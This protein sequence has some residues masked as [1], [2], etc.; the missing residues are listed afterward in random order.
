M[1]GVNRG[2]PKLQC[3]YILRGYFIVSVNPIFSLCGVSRAGKPGT[4]VEVT[5]RGCCKN[6]G[7]PTEDDEFEERARRQRVA[8][9]S[10]KPEDQNQNGGKGVK[11]DEEGGDKTVSEQP[12]VS[13][14]MIA[15]ATDVVAK[16]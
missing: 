4:R 3:V 7:E 5:Q 15:P 12:E 13:P 2:Q 14:G 8:K 11:E 6:W 1:L 10:R 9:A 16:T